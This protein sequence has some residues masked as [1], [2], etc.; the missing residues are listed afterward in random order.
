MPKISFPRPSVR[1]EN[2]Q[3]TQML[4]EEMGIGEDLNGLQQNTMMSDLYGI[5]DHDEDILMDLDDHDDALEDSGSED[6]MLFQLEE[7]QYMF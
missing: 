2:G 5:D 1:L 7:F 4:F 6:I 3:M